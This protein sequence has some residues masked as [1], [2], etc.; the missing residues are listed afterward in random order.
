MASYRKRAG[1]WRVEVYRNGRRQSATFPTKAECAAWAQRVEAELSGAALPTKSLAEAIERYAAEVAPLHR[2]AR[3]EELRCRAIVR[4][5]PDAR[6]PLATLGREDFARWR[7]ARLRVVAPA[8]VAREMTLLRSVLEAARR[9]WGWITENPIKGVRWPTT[10]PARRRRISEAEIEAVLAGLRYRRGMRPL[11]VSHRVAIAFLL[12]LETAMRSGEVCGLRWADVRPVSVVLPRTK[13]GDQREVPL[14][15]AARA[16]LDLLPAGGPGDLV[17]GVADRSRDELWRRGRAFAVAEHPELRDLADLH[18]HD[19]R[20]EAIWRLSKKLD[21]LDLA[22]VIGH[23]DPR[24][25][26]L[27]YN[28]TAEELA[29][30]LD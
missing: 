20:A 25:L 21:V 2:G 12:C 27:Y 24:S 18:F 1:S 4:D 15:R 14:S 3:W 29:A 16:L 5:W 6:L 28:A 7:D 9:D 8:S 11:T 10:P 23:R 26:M 30:R 22:R 19:A 17:L 13:N